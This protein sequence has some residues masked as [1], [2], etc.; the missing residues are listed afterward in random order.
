MAKTVNIIPAKPKKTQTKDGSS[1]PLRV[2]AYCRVS[3]DDEEQL[4]SYEN[5][6]QY[7]TELIS[8]NP[9]WEMAGIYADEDI[10][11]TNAKKRTEFLK[12]MALCRRGRVD[13]I[14]TK[15]VSRFARNTVDCLNYARLLKS[16]GIGILFEKENINTLELS[17][18]LLLTFYSSFAQAESESISKNVALGHR[19]AMKAGKVYFQYKKL[20]G[21][22]RGAN[23]EPEIIP[24]E[25][26]IIR[27]I[28]YKMLAGYSMQRIR[29][30]LIEQGIEPPRGDAAW[31]VSR[32]RRI[33]HNEI[34]AGDVLRQKTYVSDFI[35]G[36][37]KKNTGELPQ[38]YIMDN[39][40]AIVPREIYNQ[41]QAEFARRN[42]LISSSTKPTK[43][44]SGKFSSKYALTD[45]MRCGE[46]G[47]AYRRVT[48]P[49]LE[50]GGEKRI[51]WRCICR[52]ERGKEVCKD[53]PTI[54][55]R[56]LH[57]AIMESLRKLQM[58]WTKVDY[59]LQ[60]IL[61]KV[62][63]PAD[64]DTVENLDEMIRESENRMIEFMQKQMEGEIAEK[65][66]HAECTLLSHNIAILK[67]KKAELERKDAEAINS[68]DR[69]NDMM[70]L[71]KNRDLDGA[72]FD[73]VLVR[74]NIQSISVEGKN[75]LKIT[76]KNGMEVQQPWR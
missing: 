32:I 22:R 58:D 9:N 15:S 17:G 3:T 20:Y 12:L 57:A 16:K 5:Q 8:A 40:A 25:A 71:L 55:E 48:W 39:H 4:T 59:E 38:Y 50:K 60:S 31:E 47:T 56:A 34:Y 46:C 6:I 69:V 63:R 54:L 10:S 30:E 61:S 21:Y 7:Y 65:D 29:D 14:L 73:E 62:T 2:A 51:V 49:A 11:G 68:E 42:S 43:S 36:T 35:T 26:Q 28:F 23:D 74:R 33:L 44:N 1:K 41:V 67:Q 64:E 53:S 70:A 19:M 45:L 75:M 27:Q 18:E 52:L 13:L 72:E 24:H 66:W 76:F 37:V